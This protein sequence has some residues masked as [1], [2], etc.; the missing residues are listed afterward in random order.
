M[1][2]YAT[3]DRGIPQ[4]LPVNRGAQCGSV[5]RARSSWSTSVEQTEVGIS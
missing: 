2:E 1:F 3:L 4:G 5:L